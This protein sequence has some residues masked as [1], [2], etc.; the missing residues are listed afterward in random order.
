VKV[1]LADP[2][3]SSLYHKVRERGRGWIHIAWPAL[4]WRRGDG[5]LSPRQLCLR[6][7]GSAILASQSVRT[8]L[9]GVVLSI[10]KGK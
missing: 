5:S 2:P 9:E 7:M 1:F 10:R 8:R 3:G 6:S 4:G